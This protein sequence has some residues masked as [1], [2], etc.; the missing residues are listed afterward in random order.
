MVTLALLQLTL[1]FP[2]EPSLSPLT[3]ATAVAEAD[4]LWSP[5]GVP[6]AATPRPGS[7]QAPVIRVAIFDSMRAPR[8][9]FRRG[10]NERAEPNQKRPLGAI[11]FGSDGEPS[12]V[13]S[14]FMGDIL[15][16]I[17]GARLFGAVESQWPAMLRERIIGR[18]IGR[19]LAH[20]IGHY[21]LR[22][23]GHSGAGLMR[24]NHLALMLVAPERRPFA[25]SKP[26]A[27]RL[28]RRAQAPPEEA[29]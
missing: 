8:A 16:L 12:P 4:S 29:R 17:A 2:P 28:A 15:R 13:I 9:G 5:Y 26:E 7:R 25:L 6:I 20:E 22:M 11:T 1:A 14:I 18:V 24:P 19:V 23:P 27:A 3:L 10:V 21:L